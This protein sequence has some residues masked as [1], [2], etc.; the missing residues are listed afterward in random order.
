VTPDT[1][2]NWGYLL[3]LLLC[4]V[5]L[6]AALRTAYATSLG[7]AVIRAVTIYFFYLVS[8]ILIVFLLFAITANVL[9]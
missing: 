9:Y 7:F 4:T 6:I 5:Y 1:F 3:S 2:A 8:F